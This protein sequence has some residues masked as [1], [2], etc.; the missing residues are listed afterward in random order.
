MNKTN[1]IGTLPIFFAIILLALC[2]FSVFELGHSA[3]LAITIMIISIVA[4]FLLNRRM[5]TVCFVFLI[6]P[7]T[8]WGWRLLVD[9]M[10]NNNNGNWLI[11][12]GI[13]ILAI[14]IVASL[15]LDCSDSFGAFFYGFVTLIMMVFARAF[16]T[17]APLTL[18]CILLLIGII[19][20][21]GILIPRIRAKKHE[22]AIN[23]VTSRIDEINEERRKMPYDIIP[24]LECINGVG[25]DHLEQF[26]QLI[27]NQRKKH[28]DH[29]KERDMLNRRA[30]EF[31]IDRFV[32]E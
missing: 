20:T 30:S 3:I 24:F 27:E 28:E 18:F 12:M 2:V 19:V 29:L 25:D 14:G 10:W 13:V 9:A 1:S 17:N 7:F 8:I 4:R 16:G 26:D 23:S 15:Y 11:P 31:G 22:K 6:H 32:E 21:I 5:K